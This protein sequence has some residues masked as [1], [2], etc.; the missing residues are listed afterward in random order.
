MNPET[1]PSQPQSTDIS[2]V[3]Q[4][5]TSMYKSFLRTAAL[6]VVG[7]GVGLAASQVVIIEE[8][9]VST[10]EV[11][12]P[13][14]QTA[15]TSNLALLTFKSPMEGAN[16]KVTDG[17]IFISWDLVDPTILQ[18]FQK[19]KA[20]I[21]LFLVSAEGDEVISNSIG[22]APS[23]KVDTVGTLWDIERELDRGM[24]SS[25]QGTS[26][27]VSLETGKRYKIR[28]GLSYHPEIVDCLKDG[29]DS[30]SPVYSPAD[31]ALIDKAN[32]YQSDS[33][34]FT[35]DLT[36]WKIPAIR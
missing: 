5:D 26:T 30:C 24:Y 10:A 34:P 2:P 19:E 13:T 27:I 31:Q 6:L 22:P 16:F 28:A 17:P 29:P 12:S 1:S 9:K 20:Y 8:Q 11:T 25:Y 15:T 18:A 7:F 3:P 36:G 23:P 32:K 33:E 21:R 4:K 14:T 35:V